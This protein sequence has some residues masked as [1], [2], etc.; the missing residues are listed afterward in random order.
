MPSTL[1]TFAYTAQKYHDDHEAQLNA[2]SG[3]DSSAMG[4]D[5]SARWT[6]HGIRK[7]CSRAHSS[8]KRGLEERYAAYFAKRATLAGTHPRK[9]RDLVAALPPKRERLK[10]L[11]P[12][13]LGTAHS[14]ENEMTRPSDLAPDSAARRIHVDATPARRRTTT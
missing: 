9:A 6:P 3:L 7:Q 4:D 5:F 1:T 8:Y 14:A 10:Q 12:Q 13:K 2:D 11:L